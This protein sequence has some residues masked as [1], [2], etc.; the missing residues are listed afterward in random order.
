MHCETIPK[1]NFA[2]LL[3]KALKQVAVY[4]NDIS[5]NTES[6]YF[7]CPLL[8]NFFTQ[9]GICPF[10]PKIV[11]DKLPDVRPVTDGAE[12]LW[13]DNLENFIKEQ[14]FSNTRA[15]PRRC[16]LIKTPPGKSIT[17]EELTQST[18]ATVHAVEE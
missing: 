14:R 17:P 1:D 9:S 2:P 12:K 11:L 5:T 3:F 13:S 6:K 16:K 10:N 7:D 8:V 18:A 15:Q 4:P